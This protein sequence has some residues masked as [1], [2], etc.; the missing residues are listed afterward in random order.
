M[1]LKL[2]YTFLTCQFWKLDPPHFPVHLSNLTPTFQSNFQTWS[3]LPDP[4]LLLYR[5]INVI[6]FKFSF[7][8]KTA[9]LWNEQ[10]DG[11]QCIYKYMQGTYKTRSFIPYNTS[12]V[13]F[14]RFHLTRIWFSFTRRL[15]IILN[16]L[17]LWSPRQ[18]DRATRFI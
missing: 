14:N 13:N 7:P 4:L 2:T 5:A 1:Y 6:F 15:N 17:K 9:Q 8:F 18:N 12:K 10:I 11:T 3:L 16:A